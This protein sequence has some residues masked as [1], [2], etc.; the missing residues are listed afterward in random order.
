MALKIKFFT[1]VSKKN[2]SKDEATIRVRFSN[3]RKFDLSAVTELQIKPEFWSNSVG[4]YAQRAALTEREEKVHELS[5]LEEHIKKEYFSLTDKSKVN[6]DWLTEIIDKYHNPTKYKQ[7]NTTLFGFIQNFIDNSTR[8]T[9]PDTGQPVCYKMR[10]EYQVTFDYLKKYAKE[11]GNLDFIDIDMEFYQ[12]FVDFL[13]NYEERDKDGNIIK[14]GLAVNTIGKK[15]QTLKIFLNDATEQGINK[16]MKYKSRNFKALSEEAENIYLTKEELKKFYK[17]DFSNRPGLERVRDLFIVAAWTGLRYSDLQQITPEKIQGDFI[18][19]KQRKTGKK[20]T[21]PVYNA[22]NEILNK[23]NGELPKPISNQK[24][25]DF[26]K[27]AA[28]L[29][30]INSVFVKTIHKKGMRV[31]EKHP[32]H[33]LISSH[34]ARRSFCTNAYKDGVP[35]LTI[36]AISG[37]RTEKAFLKYIKVSGDEHAKEMLKTWQRNGEF[38]NVAN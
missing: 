21:I 3:G 33:K 30:K 23:Y 28:Q 9:N 7:E 2:N 19:L 24:Y 37:H 17:H 32:K 35:T 8:R 20:V 5:K 4:T 22:V 27:E 26:L 13:R 25:N 14:S 16:Y 10:R 18:H 1:R 29:A 12:Q 6:G 34:T 15:I 38:M 36:M 31:D 11:Y